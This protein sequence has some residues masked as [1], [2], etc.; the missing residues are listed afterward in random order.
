MLDGKL[1]YAENSIGE[2]LLKKIQS[3]TFCKTPEGKLLVTQAQAFF[4]NV[5]VDNKQPNVQ[6]AIARLKNYRRQPK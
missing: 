2:S 4:K 6:S 3:K 1:Q 5:P